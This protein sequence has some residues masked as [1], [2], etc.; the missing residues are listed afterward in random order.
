MSA[1]DTTTM[2]ATI[3]DELIRHPEGITAR[4]LAGATS[5]PLAQ[6]GETLRAMEAA[7]TATCTPGANG[8]KGAELW[9]PATP[10]PSN[11]TTDDSDVTD[12]AGD[13]TMTGNDE[14][15]ATPDDEAPVR[16]VSAV[17]VSPAPVSGM[18]VS[19]GPVSGVPVS[20]APAMNADFFKIVMVAGVLGDHENGV[21]AADVADESGLRAQIV[22]RV[23]GAM[24]VAGAAVR[25]PPADDTGLELWTRGEADLSA[26]D[27]SQAAVREVCPHCH[28]PMPRRANTVQV[29]R[30]PTGPTAPGQNT[31]GQPTLAKN[32]LRTIVAEFLRTHPGHEFTSGT[33]AR[34]IGRSSGAI[35]NA[36]A[37][38]VISGEAILVSEAPMKYSAAP[39]SDE[40]SVT[41]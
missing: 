39:A 3:I 23:L 40:A 8:R 36:L 34:E 4:K 11:D 1:N 33:I 38:L 31:D 9:H 20:G 41:S 13:D 17:P 27:L 22:A 30:T 28:R 7:G 2:T 6:V 35:G 19:G 18:P 26:V 21:S 10:E 37:K 16:P 32:A 24:E 15:S 5:L 14:V 12:D 29:R 25:T